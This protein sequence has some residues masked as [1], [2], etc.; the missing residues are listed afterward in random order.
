MSSHR[1]RHLIAGG[2]R[3]C[4]TRY[5]RDGARATSRPGR[6]SR[7]RVHFAALDIWAYRHGVELAFIRPGKTVENAYVES[8]HSRFRD[9][10]LAAHWF[11]D[12][13]DAGFQIERWR[14]DYNEARPHSSLGNLTPREFTQAHTTKSEP[15]TT[16]LSA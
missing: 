7:T 16:R 14:R 9:E 1:H 11:L 6:R 4:G 15:P 3:D 2:A 10:C 5:T 12:L 13:V 8:F